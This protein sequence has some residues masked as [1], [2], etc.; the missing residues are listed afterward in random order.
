MP[1]D[2]RRARGPRPQQ[3]GQR[4]RADLALARRAPRPRRRAG[5]PAATAASCASNARSPAVEPSET[6]STSTID[7]A[8][9]AAV[10]RRHLAAHARRALELH[11]PDRRRVL[12][13]ERRR[14]RAPRS[15]SPRACWLRH[16]SA[17][18]IAKP[19]ATAGICGDTANASTP[20]TSVASSSGHRRL[21]MI[22]RG[23]VLGHRR[24]RLRVG[25]QPRD[26]TG[27]ARPAP[28]ERA[29]QRRDQPPAGREQDDAV[30]VRLARGERR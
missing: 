1:V 28:E 15:R 16:A 4:E 7:Y 2:R 6:I 11:R 27:D 23:T 17:Q 5:A 12:D 21:M 20:A 9:A 19:V 22:A 14:R 10:D 8:G 29:D 18:M 3:V 30:V 25:E 13:V 26:R 24:G